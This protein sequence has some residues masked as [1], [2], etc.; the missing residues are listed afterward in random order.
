MACNRDIFTFLPWRRMREWRYSSTILYLGTRWRWVV[1]F[2]PLP[3]YSRGNNPRWPLDRT[4]GWPQS[5]SWRYG[6]WRESL[7]SAENRTLAV[8][9]VYHS[10]T[11][12]DIPDCWK[13]TPK[14]YSLKYINDISGLTGPCEISSCR[15]L[16]QWRGVRRALSPRAWRKI[17]RNLL[18][19]PGINWIS[20]PS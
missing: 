17:S 2:T 12:W 11:D 10:Y 3:L 8:Y 9:F 13:Q 5:R 7:A 20:V 1:I 19:L 16:A 6:E 4:L 15:S 18:S 14:I